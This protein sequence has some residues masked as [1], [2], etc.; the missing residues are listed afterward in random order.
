MIFDKVKINFLGCE[1]ENPFILAAT[2]STDDS[3]M[4]VEAL[5]AGWAGAILKTTAVGSSSV[6][7]KYPMMYAIKDNSG[8][9]MTLGNIDLI[10][11]H[12]LIEVARV[13]K[14]LKSKFPSKIIIPSIMGRNKKEWQLLT[15]TLI[16]SGADMIECSFS[17]PQGNIGED[18]GRMLAQSAKATEIAT[19]WVKE[20]AKDIPVLIKITPQVTDITEIAAAVKKGGGDAVV[21][22]NSVLGL[23]GIDI[24][25]GKP[26]P[27]VN[28]YGSYAGITGPSVKPIT[29]K[30]ISQ[31]AKGVGIPILGVG[32]VSN[33]KDAIELMM[34]GASIVQIGTAAMYNGFRII[35]SLNDGLNNYLLRKRFKNVNEI[36]GK[37]LPFLVGLDEIEYKKEDAPIAKINQ[38]KC[39]QCNK[40]YIACYDGGH[41][42]IFIENDKLDVDK[43]KCVG[44]GFCT[45][46]CPVDAITLKKR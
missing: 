26:L 14:K 18:P 21:V 22:T 24:E 23:I 32:G 7:L 43:E 13:V 25:T 40:C 6:D 20:A 39:I 45:G 2:P 27:T 38:D 16:K 9:M 41:Q 15:K 30:S 8:N 31:V 44:C 10:S 4:L 3:D 12:P 37:A 19:S 34:A 17:C 28:G 11:E 1:F 36:I 29:L 35:D 42:A 5:Y 46:V 33:Y